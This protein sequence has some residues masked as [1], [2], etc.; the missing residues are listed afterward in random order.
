MKQKFINNSVKMITSY[1]PNYTEYDIKKLRYGLEGIYLTITKV[2]VILAIAALVQNLIQVLLV[3]LFFNIIHFTGFGFHA[4]K[5]SVCLTLSIFNF[6]IISYL[7]L[8]TSINT[9]WFIIISLI[10][11]FFFLLYAPADTPK[12]PLKNKRK[13]L[14]RKIITIIIGFIY[15]ALGIFFNNELLTIVLVNALII[16]TIVILPLTYK[17]FKMKYRNYKQA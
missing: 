5:S 6:N 12:R 3:M 13:R 16:Q 8:M 17:I 1:N 2:A 11:I 9:F 4:D 14:I 15:L 10:C 7:L